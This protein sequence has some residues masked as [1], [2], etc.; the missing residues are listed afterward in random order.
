[1]AAAKPKTV[2]FPTP[3]SSIEHMDVNVTYKDNANSETFRREYRFAAEPKVDYVLTI[4]FSPKTTTSSML[5]RSVLDVGIAQAGTA[6]ERLHGLEKGGGAQSGSGNA[7]VSTGAKGTVVRT[8]ITG[9]KSVTRPLITVQ[10]F[11]GTARWTIAVR[12]KAVT[13]PILLKPEGWKAA[14][15]AGRDASNYL[16]KLTPKATYRVTA[17]FKSKKAGY[18]W[19]NMSRHDTASQNYLARVQVEPT[20]FIELGSKWEDH[21]PVRTGKLGV[22]GAHGHVYYRIE[23]PDSWVENDTMRVIA[24][25]GPMKKKKVKATKGVPKIKYA[26]GWIPLDVVDEAVSHKKSQAPVQ[27]GSR[28]ERVFTTYLDF[29]FGDR[30][31]V[32]VQVEGPTTFYRIKAVRMS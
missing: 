20:D 32:F 9:S 16:V 7:T 18:V 6:N 4:T 10:D 15:S 31:Y 12:T 3:R 23:K 19:L 5:D 24:E 17:E 27:A 21:T 25:S 1:M 11:K 26:G 2:S 22:S 13:K 14:R 30:A 28:T 8:K 29:D